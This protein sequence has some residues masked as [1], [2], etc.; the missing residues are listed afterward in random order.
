MSDVNYV[1]IQP[2]SFNA[3]SDT[4][5]GTE[6]VTFV[7]NPYISISEL[8]QNTAAKALGITNSSDVITSGEMANY[9]QRATAWINR[10]CQRWF[11]MQ[12]VWEVKTGFVVHPYNPQLITVRVDNG[13]PYQT[14]NQ[15]WIQV[16]RWFIQIDITS[17]QNYLQDFYAQGYYKIV[18]LLSSAGAGTGSPLPAAIVDRIPLGILWTDY[19]S[20]FGTQLTGYNMGTGDGT[21]TVFQAATGNQLWCQSNNLWTQGAHTLESLT[22][23]D[24]GTV[25]ASSDYTVDYVNGKLTFNTAPVDGHNITADF[26]TYEGIPHDIKYGTLL[27][28]LH[29]WAVDNF[30]PMNHN[31]L[32]V[33]GL[34]ISYSD[35]EKFMKKIE[36]MLQPYINKRFTLI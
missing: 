34:N 5:T 2:G 33:P 14:I 18:P 30:N 17:D 27:L 6:F 10:Y 28:A 36:D 31:N 1:P 22:V 16:L 13:P 32:S 4:P 19:T 7:D 24:N 15:I 20:G 8:L 29:Y 9:I 12:R 3:G 11:D 21:T 26:W 23:Y 35:E 25:V